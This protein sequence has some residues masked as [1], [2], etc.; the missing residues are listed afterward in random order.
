MMS[1][2]SVFSKLMLLLDEVGLR[3]RAP[4]A[5]R[6][7]RLVGDD[8]PL[9]RALRRSST[10]PP[11]PAAQGFC[12][13]SGA[14]LLMRVADADEREQAMSTAAAVFSATASSVS[15]KN[16][17]RSLWP[18][19]TMVAP[20]SLTIAAEIS[21]VQAPSSAQCMFCAPTRTVVPARRSAAIGDRGEGRDDEQPGGLGSRDRRAGQR[22]AERV[23][24]RARL[25]HLPAG[26]DPGD[27]ASSV[28]PSC[29]ESAQCSPTSA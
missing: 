11:T 18:S 16:S 7:D 2:V 6:P 19:S 13:S 28:L 22:A 9:D 8:D 29:R 20:T 14:E 3:R 10:T 1:A 15:L 12:R 25:V 24:L 17:R 23:R 27:L 21:P 5:D 26:A 4:L